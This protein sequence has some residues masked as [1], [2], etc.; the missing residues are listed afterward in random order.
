MDS[1]KHVACASVVVLFLFFFL[2]F[3]SPF[4]VSF[5][6]AVPSPFFLRSRFCIV[7]RF[8]NPASASTSC[9]LL[10]PY[11]SNPP[12][13]G[14]RPYRRFTPF[15]RLP[16]SQQNSIQQWTDLHSQSGLR[17]LAIETEADL[18]LLARS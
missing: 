13:A 6:L 9:A 8:L 1:R 10:H 3:A 12:A 15:H 17:E 5:S 11:F 4:G 18:R 14:R 16:S 2:F 7:Q